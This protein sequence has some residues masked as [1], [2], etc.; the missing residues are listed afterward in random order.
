MAD[1]R[2]T[3]ARRWAGL[4]LLLALAGLAVLRSHWG[5]RLDGFTVDEPWHVVAGVSY[6][7]TGDFRL[8]QPGVVAADVPPLRNPWME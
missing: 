5:T 8:A 3:N 6:L 7:R 2:G 1:R 4:A